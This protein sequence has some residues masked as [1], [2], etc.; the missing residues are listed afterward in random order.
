MTASRT[1]FD[2]E[3]ERASFESLTPRMEYS[4]CPL[5][6]KNKIISKNLDG[7]LPNLLSTSSFGRSRS[8]RGQGWSLHCKYS[9][10]IVSPAAPIGRLW[11]QNSRCGKQKQHGFSQTKQNKTI[12]WSVEFSTRRF[13]TDTWQTRL[14]NAFISHHNDAKQPSDKTQTKLFSLITLRLFINSCLLFPK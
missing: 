13:A 10:K 7:N 11:K 4:L 12:I 6:Q 2:F 9:D 1:E 3:N 14:N 5:C 8:A